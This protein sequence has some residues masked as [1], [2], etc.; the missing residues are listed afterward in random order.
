MTII[1]R[2]EA[3]RSGL[4]HADNAEAEVQDA[5]GRTGEAAGHDMADLVGALSDAA[6]DLD[7]V[8]RVV[9][10]VIAEHHTNTESCIADFLAS[11][12]QLGGRVPWACSMT[13]SPASGTS[14]RSSRTSISGRPGTQPRPS[15]RGRPGRRDRDAA[16]RPGTRRPDRGRLGVAPDRH[17][18]RRRLRRPGHLP[19]Q[20]RSSGLG[21]HVGRCLPYLR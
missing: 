6:D 15:S 2:P 9:L 21:R 8:L 19:R 11:D 17:V 10:G 14:S 12:G 7:G 5:R 16:T 3:V 4:H 1:L 20:D 13:P 18:R